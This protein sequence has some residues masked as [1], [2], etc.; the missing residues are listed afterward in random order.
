MDLN[1]SDEH[2]IIRKTAREFVETHITPH[3]GDWEAKGDIPDTVFREMAKLGFLGAPI[4]EEYGGAGLDGIGYAVLTEEIA[5]GCSSLRTAMSVQSSLAG[6]T[7]LRFGSEEQKDRWL[8]PLASGEKL[9]AWALTESGSG[10]DAAGMKTR[11]VKRDGKY[12]LGGSKMWISQG[13]K[14]DILVVFAKTDPSKKHE[15][16]SAFVVEKGIAGFKPGSVET[17][18]KLGLRS[19]HTAELLFED[20]E[21]PEENRIGKEGEGWNAAM[22]TLNHGR[23]SVAAGAVGIMQAALDASAEYAKKRQA[24]G[25][26]IGDFQLV[27]A[28]LADMQVKT[29]AGRMLVWKAA[30]VKDAY[31]RGEATYAEWSRAVSIAKLYT[32]EACVEVAEE[33]VQIHGANGYTNEYPVERYWRDAKICG[34]YEGTNEIQRLLIGRH[35]LGEEFKLE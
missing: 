4:P 12:V 23:L 26:P 5:K 7:L 33:G 1:L 32:A 18:N 27:K 11:A 19:S 14:A 35:V 16:V 9:G 29:E 2:E 34:I 24:F 30:L 25:R 31:H 17:T 15:G 20:C 13:D 8:K 22:Y 3:V 21:L 10:S 28:K 6:M